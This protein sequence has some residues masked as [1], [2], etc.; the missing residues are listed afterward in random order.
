MILLFV[1]QQ[2]KEQQMLLKESTWRRT[3]RLPLVLMDWIS[4]PIRRTIQ[5]EYLQVNGTSVR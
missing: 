5:T 3:T 1:T 4:P 2:R